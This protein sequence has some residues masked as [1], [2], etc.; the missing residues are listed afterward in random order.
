MET[1]RCGKCE[2]EKSVYEFHKDNHHKDG[3]CSQCKKCRNVIYKKIG[4]ITTIKKLFNNGLK[5]CPNCKKIKTLNMF[6]KNK[7]N[8]NGVSTMCKECEKERGTDYYWKNYE[9]I[10]VDKIMNNERT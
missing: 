1:K 8:T 9:K 10:H 4:K 7:N 5:R 3:L 2:K 6:G